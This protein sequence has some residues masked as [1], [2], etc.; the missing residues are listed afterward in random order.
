MYLWLNFVIFITSPRNRGGV[1]FSLQFVCVYVCVCVSVCLCVQFSCEQNSSQT[2]APIWTR[3]SLNGCFPHW[4]KPYWIWWPW[5]KGQGYSDVIPIFLYNF[6][7]TS[8]LC[9][10]AILCLIKLKFGMSL[11]RPLVVLCLNF[12]KI[13]WVMTSLWRPLSF[14]QT[15]VHISN[16][17]EPINF[18][19]GTNS[20][21][22]TQFP[23]IDKNESDLD[24][25][26]KY[27]PDLVAL[28]LSA[29]IMYIDLVNYFW[30]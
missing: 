22:I 28:Q 30:S 4:L 5:V 26:W 23:Y 14:L 7:L 9:I 13:E 17:I 15:I 29:V 24:G 11:S 25:R 21:T 10:S 12:I 19:L 27:Q 3:F 20:I 6:L 1:I 8:L 2:D 18:V 16:S